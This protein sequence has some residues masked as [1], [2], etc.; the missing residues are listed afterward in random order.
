MNGWHKKRPVIAMHVLGSF[1]ALLFAA[2][3]FWL[4]ARPVPWA[5]VANDCSWGITLVWVWRRSLYP[6]PASW[7]RLG[8]AA[9]RP[10]KRALRTVLVGAWIGVLIASSVASTVHGVPGFPGANPYF[11]LL[12]V[13]HSPLHPSPLAWGMCGAAIFIALDVVRACRRTD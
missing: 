12:G 2:G 11:P 8:R 10:I 1:G 7:L 6:R 9:S 3:L 4:T 13:A 5:E